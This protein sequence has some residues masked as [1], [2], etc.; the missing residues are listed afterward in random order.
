M[1]GI[2]LDCQV[3]LLTDCLVGMDGITER[4]K[5]VAREVKLEC[6]MVE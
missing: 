4:E 5:V 2:E 6:V 3:S 1:D